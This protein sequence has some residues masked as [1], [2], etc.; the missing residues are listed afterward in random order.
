[1]LGE[2]GKVLNVDCSLALNKLPSKEISRLFQLYN[3]ND[4]FHITALGWL[5][6]DTDIRLFRLATLEYTS[7]QL[8]W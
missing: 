1:M 6:Q 8:L 5:R 7:S 3:Y 4:T 2:H